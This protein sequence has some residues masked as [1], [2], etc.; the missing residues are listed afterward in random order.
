MEKE[1]KRKNKIQKTS[2]AKKWYNQK[3]GCFNKD[4]I[5]FNNLLLEGLVKSHS[6]EIRKTTEGRMDGKNS[7]RYFYISNNEFS[8]FVDKIKFIFEQ[9]PFS[10]K[11]LL[12]VL[13]NQKLCIQLMFW[14][15][16]DF[17]KRSFDESYQI[18]ALQ[19]GANTTE[20]DKI[21]Y[22]G[23]A[24]VIADKNAVCIQVFRV[25]PCLSNQL[26]DDYTQYMYSIHFP[27]SSMRF[28]SFISF[29][30][31]SSI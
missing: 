25:K 27:K 31:L 12:Q 18:S 22:K 21:T 8:E 7:A 10:K 9:H 2:F 14:N 24:D 6:S 20:V 17:R 30:S 26:Q 11:D 15:D 29:L 4:E 19:Q 1:Q 23:D 3:T 13:N 5:N 28:G 16:N